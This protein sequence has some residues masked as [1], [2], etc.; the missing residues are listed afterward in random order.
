M[1]EQE[2]IVLWNQLAAPGYYRMGLACDIGFDTAKPGQF[3]M[4]RT[5][6]D[7]TPLLRRP[8]SLLGLIREA[9]RV[10]GI[11]ILFKVVGKGTQRLSRCRNGDRL[12]VIGQIPYTN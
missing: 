12:S 9:D 2:T 3:I 5:G 10:T 7:A 11:E 4:V 8:F 1:I 6:I